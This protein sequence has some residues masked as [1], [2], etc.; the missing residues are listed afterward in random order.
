[1]P[2]NKVRGTA[3][4]LA[5][6]FLFT[7]S[8]VRAG[9]TSSEE[10]MSRTTVITD[11]AHK[12]R[13][14]GEDQN[15]SQQSDKNDPQWIVPAPPEKGGKRGGETWCRIVVDNWTPWKIQLYLEGHTHGLVGPF[16][17]LAIHNPGASSRVYARAEFKD[18]PT[19]SWGPRVFAC[20]TDQPYRW[21]LTQ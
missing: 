1:M 20:K 21:K 4:L 11:R 7:L 17:E 15:I 5:V 6:S 10:H 3:A 19:R 18:G 14:D 16:G 13:G 9:G 2:E 12:S 8:E